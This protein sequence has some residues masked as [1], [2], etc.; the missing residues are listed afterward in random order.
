MLCP[1]RS[2]SRSP[3]IVQ[4][5]T[6]PLTPVSADEDG[7]EPK[8]F[9]FPVPQATSLETTA[10]ST[11]ISPRKQLEV[12]SESSDARLRTPTR[13]RRRRA[14]ES[15]DN[16]TLQVSHLS[17]YGGSSYSSSVLS[18]PCPSPTVLRK[19]GRSPAKGSDQD[20]PFNSQQ[21]SP[22]KSPPRCQT[23]PKRKG[24]PPPPPYSRYNTYTYSV[25]HQQRQ[26]LG[27]GAPVPSLYG[28]L[29]PPIF[30]G[31]SSRQIFG[32]SLTPEASDDFEAAS[33]F[34]P[35]TPMNKPFGVSHAYYDPSP[36]GYLPSPYFSITVKSPQPCIR[37]SSA[38]DS[39]STSPVSY[40]L[41]LGPDGLHLPSFRFPS[42]RL[43]WS[44]PSLQMS[45]YDLRSL[46]TRLTAFG[47]SA[48]CWLVLYFV[49]NLGLTLYNK[50]VLVRF[51][52][53]YTL[54]ALHTFCGS[55]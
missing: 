37:V 28:Q 9:L 7:L 15:S 54:T 13:D 1:F 34:G 40:E 11:S 53:P 27:H 52:Y 19:T 30:P 18:S 17:P 47:D 8:R 49:F 12:P 26:Q 32:G 24:P 29:P 55:V 42:I 2:P 6:P 14:M 46:A 38:P 50:G 48:G 35:A 23:S 44:L 43:D 31:P 51:P 20:S 33:P 41:E 25:K 21:S 5:S 39:G 4:P 36:N 22:I 10:G 16:E 45:L 3:L